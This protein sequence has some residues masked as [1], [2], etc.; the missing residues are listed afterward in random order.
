MTEVWTKWEGQ[1]INGVFPLRRFLSASEHSAVFLTEYKAQN[2]A[3]AA[4][5]LIQ[6]NPTQSQ[7]QL[8]HWTTAAKLS[9][10][11]LIRLLETGRCQLGG[12]PFL[13]V[14]MEYAEQTLAQ[15]L[16][17]RALT[18]DEVRELLVPT[19]EAM[20]FLHRRNLVLGQLKPS[21]ILVVNDQV[22]LA[23]DTVRPAGES[24]PTGAES[25]EYDAPETKLGSFSRAGDIWSLGLTLVEALTQHPTLW[26]DSK[27]ETEF[28]PGAIPPTL[29]KIIRQ[30]LNR[31]PAD[32]PTVA[33]LQAEINPAPAV[34]VASIPQ[35]PVPQPP[36]PAPKPLESIPEPVVRA[37]PVR[38]QPAEKSRLP[39]WLVPAVAVAFIVVLALW[40]GV[41]LLRSQYASKPAAPPTPA[42]ENAESSP[43]LHPEAAA[44]RPV[45]HPATPAANSA[46]VLHEEIPDVPPHAR[47]T[48]RGVIK[49]AVRVTVD[50]SGNVVDE[51]LEVHGSSYYFARLAMN[52]ASKWKFVP[53]DNPHARKWLLRFEFSRSGVTGHAASR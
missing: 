26:P 27:S 31:N 38:A 33:E 37:A 4:I 44:A 49:I 8:A 43:P 48:I 16:P 28:L 25:A 45:D 6:A 50:P 17:K 35:P 34:V 39:R 1:V 30:S 9:H 22:K 29:E 13:F 24:A 19:L 42:A 7:S 14:V 12:L 40:A 36:V 2:L 23:S 41:H 32:R 11:H 3:N 52:A 10:P 47:G 21:N 51:T 18:P 46:S 20:A 5:K 53:A 15:I